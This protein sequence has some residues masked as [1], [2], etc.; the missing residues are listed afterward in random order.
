L[1]HPSPPEE[2]IVAKVCSEYQQYCQGGLANGGVS[3]AHLENS[4]WIL[5]DLCKFC[6]ALPY[7][8]AI[9]A[10]AGTPRAKA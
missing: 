3:K 5:N 7:I 6:G 4:T 10:P 1:A 9:T 8:S 2:W